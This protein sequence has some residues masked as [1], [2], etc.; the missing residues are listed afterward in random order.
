MAMVGSWPWDGYHG[1]RKVPA[2]LHVLPLRSGQGGWAGTEQQCQQVCPKGDL[3]HASVFYLHWGLSGVAKLIPSPR[4][5]PTSKAQLW[6]ETLEAGA[7]VDPGRCC[8]REPGAEGFSLPG[9]E[10]A[11]CTAI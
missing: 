8:S 10:T 5:N 11:L 7:G 2:G 4:S 3:H 6:E 1:T 9:A